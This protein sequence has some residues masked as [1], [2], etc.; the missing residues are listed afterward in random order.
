MHICLALGYHA[1]GN[2]P[3]SLT[4]VIHA[5][6]YAGRS[7]LRLARSAPPA[8][9]QQLQ[10]FNFPVAIPSMRNASTDTSDSHERSLQMRFATFCS[11]ISSSPLANSRNQYLI[12][13]RGCELDELQTIICNFRDEFVEPFEHGIKN[14]TL[15]LA[16]PTDYPV[17]VL[18]FGLRFRLL[19]FRCRLTTLNEGLAT[20]RFLR[21]QR[22]PTKTLQGIGLGLYMLMRQHVHEYA[23]EIDKHISGCNE[24][25]L[26]SLEVEFRLVQS[27][28]VGCANQVEH[29]LLRHKI[30]NKTSFDRVTELIQ[31]YPDTAGRLKDIVNPI[32]RFADGSPLRGPLHELLGGKDIHQELGRHKIGYLA[33]CENGHPYSTKTFKHCPECGPKASPLIDYNAMLASDSA[34]WVADFK[35]TMALGKK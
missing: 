30:D 35:K 33:H 26:K 32:Q 20:A 6:A 22:D 8:L 1:L 34:T 24:R 5:A 17:P 21:Q 11:G 19:Y 27:C 3:V 14:I 7:A 23:E 18:S 16:S 2:A 15:L 29:N 9:S 28:F 10:R 31:A 4:A 12:Q 13:Q 25:Q